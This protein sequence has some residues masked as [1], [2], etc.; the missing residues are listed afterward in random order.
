MHIR[1]REAR[2]ASDDGSATEHEGEDG[3]GEE[4]G[5]DDDEDEDS[6]DDDDGSDGEE[7]QELTGYNLADVIA[8]KAHMKANGLT[9]AFVVQNVSVSKTALYRW[10]GGI[11]IHMK[12]TLKAGMAVRE[13]MDSL[14][15]SEKDNEGGTQVDASATCHV[16][17]FVVVPVGVHILRVVFAL[18]PEKISRH[19]SPEVREVDLPLTP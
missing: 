4:D 5:E 1:L 8:C 14:S 3:E 18:C 9:Q 12:S 16:C 15:P 10:L 6:N 11:D 13:W 17:T 19:G 2:S 7:E